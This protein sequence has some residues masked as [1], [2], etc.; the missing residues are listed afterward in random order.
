MAPTVPSVEPTVAAAGSTW[1]WTAS[2]TEYPV[3]EGW[4]LS[5]S[6][7]GVDVPTWST[8][9]ISNDG[10]IHT[11]TIPYGTT[12][13]LRPGRYELSRIW[14]GASAYSGV[15]YVEAL[16]P[17]TVTANPSTVA[18]GDRVA[19]AEANLAAVE[20]AL[21]AR[22]AG[23]Q[24]EE[25]SIGGRSV[26]KMSVADLEKSRGRLQAELWR[27]RHPWIGHRSLAVEFTRP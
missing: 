21:T 18:P 13:T 9:W 24:P 20:A 6:V 22:Y 16:P 2:S 1:T 23:D 19:F 5:Y 26:K 27:L 15:R 10:S 3:S 25:Y 7:A 4:V 11:V 14:T 17:L 12:A 8:G